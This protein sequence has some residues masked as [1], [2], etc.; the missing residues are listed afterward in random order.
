MIRP[1]HF[2]PVSHLERLAKKPG[3][4]PKRVSPLKDCAVLT[5]QFGETTTQILS[6]SAQQRA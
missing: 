6:L 4:P 2:A 3:D 1:A 5:V